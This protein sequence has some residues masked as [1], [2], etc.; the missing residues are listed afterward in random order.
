[1]SE[2]RVAKVVCQCDALGE[3]LVQPQGSGYRA[4]N[5]CNLDG[6]GETG[7]KQVALVIDEYLCLVLEAAKRGR[8]DDTVAV[9]LVFATVGR[10]RGLLLQPFQFGRV[11]PF[12]R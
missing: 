2:R 12:P 3:I 8:M 11:N 10:C 6:V 1:M 5:L 9:A 4:R 7:A